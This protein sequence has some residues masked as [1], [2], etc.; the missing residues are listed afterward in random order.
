[1]NQVN[2]RAYFVDDGEKNKGR[3]KYPNWL[4]KIIVSMKLSHGVRRFANQQKEKLRKATD[5]IAWKTMR[6]DFTAYTIEASIEGVAINFALHFIFGLQFTPLKALAY[7]VLAKQI[8]S[9]YWRLNK[10]NENK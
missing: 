8:L 2:N 6:N 3:F 4:N 1:M 5:A 10:K 7:G 9:F